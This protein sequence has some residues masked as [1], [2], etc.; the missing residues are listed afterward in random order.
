MLIVAK[1]NNSFICPMNESYL[2]EVSAAPKEM[3]IF[4]F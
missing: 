2:T 3:M 4:L 1:N